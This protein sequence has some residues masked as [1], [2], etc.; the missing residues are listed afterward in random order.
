MDSSNPLYF[1]SSR[2]SPIFVLSYS[3]DPSFSLSSSSLL[4]STSTR[5]F[6]TSI[7]VLYAFITSSTF[8]LSVSPKPLKYWPANSAKPW[9]VSLLSYASF[10]STSPDLAVSSTLLIWLYFCSNLSREFNPFSSLSS[11]PSLATIAIPYKSLTKSSWRAL[12]AKSLKSIVS[13][14]D[15]WDL[16]ISLCRPDML[17]SLFISWIHSTLPLIIDLNQ[18]KCKF[19]LINQGKLYKV[20]DILI[21]LWY[22][23]R[24]SAQYEVE[25]ALCPNG[26]LMYFDN[27]V[28]N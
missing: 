25:V 27:S 6:I 9:R 17:L 28:R 15:C 20:I 23:H 8:F 4:K 16:S 1:A 10:S 7:S 11:K 5:A 26:K 22:N 12:F 24:Q 13:P 14:P 19:L 18:N 3:G 2:P 21:I